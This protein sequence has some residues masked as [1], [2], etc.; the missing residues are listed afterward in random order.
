MRN[1]KIFDIFD[2][3]SEKIKDSIIKR[4]RER[5]IEEELKCRLSE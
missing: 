2:I 3:R 1:K 4:D 5:Y